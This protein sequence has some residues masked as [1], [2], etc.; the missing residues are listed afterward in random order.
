MKNVIIDS[1]YREWIASLSG[2]YRRAQIKASVEVNK[3]LLKFYWQ[4][5]HDI[6]QRQDEN[7]YGSGFF[8]ILSK[9][10]KE[11]LPEAKCFSEKNLYYIRCFYMMFSEIFPQLGGNSSIVILNKLEKQLYNVTEKNQ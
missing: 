1:E 11:A 9:D 10:L 4:L 6:I 2:R 3:E 5:G 7:K 8:K